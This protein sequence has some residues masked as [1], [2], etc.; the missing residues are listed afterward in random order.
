MDWSS[1]AQPVSIGLPPIGHLQAVILIGETHYAG[2]KHDKARICRRG[3]TEPTLREEN[4]LERLELLKPQI[5]IF[6]RLKQAYHRV[7]LQNLL[8]RSA[9]LALFGGRGDGEGGH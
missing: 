9:S 7:D 6:Q 1:F 8:P 4:G 5:Q 2:G 3:N